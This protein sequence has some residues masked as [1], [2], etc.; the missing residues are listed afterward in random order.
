MASRTVQLCIRNEKPA[1]K[2]T[3]GHY[4]M[5]YDQLNK[6]KV[7]LSLMDRSIGVE[8]DVSEICLY[9]VEH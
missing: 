9:L 6:R 2:R 3:A 7:E 8:I 4:V 5:L 1:A